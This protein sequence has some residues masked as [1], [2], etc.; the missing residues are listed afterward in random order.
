MMSVMTI[1]SMGSTIMVMT[2]SI[3]MPGHRLVI[4]PM[5][6][7]IILISVMGFSHSTYND[8]DHVYV[9]P[10]HDDAYV[11]QHNV[12]P[13]R[14]YLACL[15]FMFGYG[16]IRTVMTSVSASFGAAVMFSGKTV[17]PSMGTLLSLSAI[18]FPKMFSAL[19]MGPFMGSVMM[20]LSRR[21]L[22]MAIGIGHGGGGSQ[23][24]ERPI[25]ECQTTS[26]SSLSCLLSFS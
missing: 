25:Q 2:L 19:F 8:D 22:L 14:S 1:F 3:V 16:A 9:Q 12:P 24:P 18:I 17:M 21:P 26:V 4:G 6:P 15:S 10:A 5:V 11:W 13:A 7:V 20:L 23:R